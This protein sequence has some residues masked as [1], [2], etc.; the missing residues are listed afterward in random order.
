MS[1]SLIPGI[2]EPR[3]LFRLA[4]RN[5]SRNR[6]RTWISA[7]TVAFAI[8][9]LQ[10]SYAM[11]IGLE[12]QSFDNLINYQTSHA[13]LYAPGYFDEREDL[14]LDYA[15]QTPEIIQTKMAEVV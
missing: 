15:V 9:L 4:W 11:L 12:D 14:S 6:R 2:L 10:L 7:I 3:T 13:K 1:D 8:F 5:L